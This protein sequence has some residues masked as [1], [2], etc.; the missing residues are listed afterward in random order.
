LNINVT[1][2]A[3]RQMITAQQI[4]FI[5][6]EPDLRREVPPIAG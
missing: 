4:T 5:Y 1:T 2:R 3:E 6:N